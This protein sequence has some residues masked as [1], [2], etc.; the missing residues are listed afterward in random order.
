MGRRRNHD[1]HLPRRMQHQH[2][3]YYLI[4]AGTGKWIRLDSDYAIALA[5]YGKLV[6]SKTSLIT[7]RDVIDR[8]RID[9][10][11]AKAPKTQKEQSREL[12][13]LVRVFGD[14][15][16]EDITPQHIYRYID[17]RIDKPSA[18]SHEVSLLRHVFN[19][20]I[21]WG[22]AKENPVKFVEKPRSKPR[23]RYVTDEEFLAVYN[24]ASPRLQITMDLALLTGLRRGDLL[25][26]TRDHLTEEGILIK[27]GKSGKALIIEY[28]S[29]LRNVLDRAKKIHPQVPGKYIIRTQSGTAYS[30]SGFSA[31]WKRLMRKAVKTGIESFT[32]HDLR[33]KSASDTADIHEASA[34]LGHSS[35]SITQRVYIRVPTRVRPLK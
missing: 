15:R 16:P 6:G 10:L 8:Y 5:E 27:T 3:A 29:D 14:C 23:D 30:P 2:G 1:K 31:N 33:A 28:S 24:L 32:F 11:T 13:R 26:L 18:A 34:R 25:S 20:A 17:E 35:V 12:D 22:A 9:I 4:D 21:R 19:K 7:I